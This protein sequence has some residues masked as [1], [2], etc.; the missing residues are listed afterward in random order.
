MVAKPHGTNGLPC[1]VWNQPFFPSRSINTSILI[2]DGATVVMGGMISEIRQSVD[3]KI[4]FL[5]EI[6]IFGR[7][8]RSKSDSSEK[9]NLLIFVTA[10]LV[11]PAGRRVGKPSSVMQAIAAEPAVPER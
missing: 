5:G 4:P 1:A 8:F 7:L 3:D 10:R 2:Y 6:P 11:D 9:R